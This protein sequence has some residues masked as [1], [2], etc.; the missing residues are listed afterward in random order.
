MTKVKVPQRYSYVAA[1]LSMQCNLG[2]SYCIN[3]FDKPFSR[4]YSEMSAEEWARAINRLDLPKGLPVTLQG[5]EPT[6][7]KDFHN[8]LM[9]IKK[10]VSLDMLTNGQFDINEFMSE[11]PPSRF[12]QFKDG[13]EPFASIRI[14][15][16]PTE[17]D[18]DDIIER[19]RKLKQNGYSVG[20]SAVKHPTLTAD[21]HNAQIACKTAGIHFWQ[22]EFL[23]FFKGKLYG[24]YKYPDAVNSKTKNVECKISELLI[25]PDGM[26]YR[27]HRDLYHQENPVGHILDEDFKIEDVFR[28]CDKF[29]QCNPCDS[30]EKCDRFLQMG[31]CSVEIKRKI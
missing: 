24:T 26:V 20:I 23:G 3:A 12:R 31:Y 28:T 25:A 6:V 27:C 2:C 10:R 4:Q 11:I 29:G 22:K 9:G 5:G 17:M 8:I 7:R 1:F 30:K 19:A 18:L 14:S 21:I 16:H 15:Y 13:T